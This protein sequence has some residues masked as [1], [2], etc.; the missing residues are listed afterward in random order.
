MWFPPSS[1]LNDLCFTQYSFAYNLLFSG[2]PRAE[3]IILNISEIKQS[4]HWVPF[5]TFTNKSLVLSFSEIIGRFSFTPIDFLLLLLSCFCFFLRCTYNKVTKEIS[6]DLFIKNKGSGKLRNF[7][8]HK[9]QQIGTNI[10]FNQIRKCVWKEV[11]TFFQVLLDII[12]P[13]RN[14]CTLP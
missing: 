14:G 8:C 7:L 10:K 3:Q 9:N 5:I 13:P 11:F 6:C 4:F 1:S 2:C 12:K